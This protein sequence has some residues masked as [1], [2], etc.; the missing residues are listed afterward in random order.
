MH[1]L[2]A[3]A[4]AVADAGGRGTGLVIGGIAGALLATAAAC[5]VVARRRARADVAIGGAAQR[6]DF[7]PAPRIRG[8]ASQSRGARSRP[9]TPKGPF[10][11]DIPRPRR[12]VPRPLLIIL[13]P[14]LRHSVTR[15]AYVLRGVGQRAGPVL[16]ENRRHASLPLTGPE[17][18]GAPLG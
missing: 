18:R 7:S 3:P 12:Y 1:A 9:F 4:A 11:R 17:R 14:V 15:D 13:R 10:V 2:S 8:K 6:S 16:R 5:V